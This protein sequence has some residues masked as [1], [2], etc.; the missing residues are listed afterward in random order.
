MFSYMTFNLLFPYDMSFLKKKKIVEQF[1]TF[2]QWFLVGKPSLDLLQQKLFSDEFDKLS[3]VLFPP[4]KGM[5]VE[6]CLSVFTLS[7]EWKMWPWSLDYDAQIRVLC[8]EV[9]AGV[10]DL[11]LTKLRNA[12]SLLLVLIMT[13]GKWSSQTHL[14][15]TKNMRSLKW[16]KGV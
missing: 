6:K 3:N 9:L 13:C 10:L 15:V 5:S 11:P 4:H 14:T 1:F 8:Q 7:R 12:R 16:L 2:Y